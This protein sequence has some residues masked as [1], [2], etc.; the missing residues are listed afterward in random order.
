MKAST[1][2]WETSAT[3]MIMATALKR[4]TRT[5]TEPARRLFEPLRL[6]ASVCVCV[7][8]VALL[9]ACGGYLF[10]VV[11][12]VTR[13]IMLSSVLGFFYFFFL[14]LFVFTVCCSCRCLRTLLFFSPSFRAVLLY[15]ILYFP[16][17][18]SLNACAC[19]VAVAVARCCMLLSP[20][21]H[22]HHY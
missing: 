18:D 1:A 2:F 11:A 3:P 6:F 8:V 16:S 12:V 9:T 21:R 7:C 10:Y 4:Q 22:H 19:A 13:L 5:A 20:F 17:V 15:Y 14:R